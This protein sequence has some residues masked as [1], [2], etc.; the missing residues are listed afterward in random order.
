MTDLILFLLG[1]GGAGAWYGW[2]GYVRRTKPCRHCAGW[3]YTERRGIIGTTA[4]RC[5]KCGGTGKTFRMAARR[6]QRSRARRSGRAR[7]A[8]GVTW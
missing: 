4:R 6:V 2:T 3:G 5:K 1:T 7:S 8:A